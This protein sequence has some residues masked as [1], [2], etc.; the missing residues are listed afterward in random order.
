MK[1][2][3]Q[4]IFEAIREERKEF[5]HNQIEIVD[6]LQFNQYD[7]I[8]KIH[9]YYQSHY[10][11]GDYETINGI[12]LKK[13]F[14]N[15]NKWRCDVATKMLD[16]DVKDFMFI[17][18]N[19]HV[20]EKVKLFEKELKLWL[21]KSRMGKVLND[22]ARELPMCGSVVVRKVPGGAEVVDLRKLMN[23]PSARS[24]EKARYVILRHDMTA[25]DLRE[26]EGKWNDTDIVI[27]RYCSLT[28]K[29]YEDASGLN[30][31]LGSPFAEV[32]ETFQEVPENWLD[33]EFYYDQTKD[34][35]NFVKARFIVAG[36][37]SYSTDTNTGAITTENG[38]VLFSEEVKQLPMK[39]IHY[40][41]VR[42]RW[43]GMGVVEDTFEDQRIV[44]KVKDAELRAYELS[45]LILFQTPDELV[46]KNLMADVVNGD[47]L[48]AKNPIN[49]LDNTNKALAEGQAISQAYELHAD[50]M[51]FSQDVIR[52]EQ[53]P[54]STTATAVVNQVQQAASVY[55]FKREDFSLG[56]EEFMEDLVY[57]EA[58][59]DLRKAHQ[60]RFSGDANELDRVRNKYFNSQSFNLMQQGV[61]PL[62]EVEMETAKQNFMKDMQEQGGRVFMD[63]EDNWYNDVIGQFQLE[64]SGESKNVQAQLAYGVQ[65]LQI[66]GSNPAIIEN[67][68][69]RLAL[70]KVLQGMGMSLSEF[71]A[72]VAEFREKQQEQ[73]QQQFQQQMQLEQAKRPQQVQIPE[74]NTMTN[75]GV[76]QGI[77]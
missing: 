41:R 26:M 43:L 77:S 4:S 60:F 18:D 34:S 51:T 29:S 25:S 37:D 32:Y 45:N 72:A 12:T 28:T 2:Y 39:E 9:K 44:N 30:Q 55:D 24:L 42:G 8:K 15:I 66:L 11:D 50:R 64:I 27:D 47:M 48:K 69:T 5:L 49:R 17:A 65:L 76:N 71:D 73:Q 23:D 57:P 20:E 21:K 19:P 61:M 14:F 3:P 67:P 22:I 1:Y 10:V 36:I 38:L 63:V 40:S 6:G 7:T 54:A 59:K 16:L 35:R 68:V 58:K 52:G 31:S 62:D 13:V 74:L 56:L 33:G 70:F 75:A 46:H 53:P